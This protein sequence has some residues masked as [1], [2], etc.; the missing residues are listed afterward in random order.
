LPRDPNVCLHPE[1]NRV[2]VAL[3][4]HGTC[5]LTNHHYFKHFNEGDK[6]EIHISTKTTPKSVCSQQFN[7]NHL[8]RIGDTDLVVYKCDTSL[9]RS[10]SLVKHFPD[11][12][13]VAQQHEAVI[14]TVFPVP[15]IVRGV[16]ATP[17]TYK[18]EYGSMGATYD[19]L[20]SYVTNV[21]SS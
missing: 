4:V 6:F 16:T 7:S 8:H 5:I 14:S 15:S 3:R 17:I 2:N 13:I 18:L 20:N 21:P 1:S 10:R 11:E 19:L 12:E 9:G